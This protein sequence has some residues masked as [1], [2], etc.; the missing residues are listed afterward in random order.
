[1]SHSPSPS[2]NQP[3]SFLPEGTRAEQVRGLGREG[4]PATINRKQ[5]LAIMLSGRGSNMVALVDA[6][7][8]GALRELAE[9]AVVFSNNP[10]APGLATAAALGC[11]T[12]NLAPAGR[13]RADY[14]AAVVQLLREYELDYLVLAG[15]MRIL[16]P[17]LVRAYA[18]RILNIH[19]A[20]THL[21][22]GLHAYEWA[23]ENKL[24]ETKITVHLV[25][26]GLDTGPVLAQRPVDLR[27]ANTLSEVE[28]R[29]LLVEHELYAD[30]LVR[31]FRGQI[32]PSTPASYP[33]APPDNR[34]LTTEN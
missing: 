23:F 5:R 19:P 2:E 22:Q 26:E 17:V 6:I 24:P 8:M 28:R 27:G 20:D 3:P 34:Q 4:E 7:Q 25:N 9:V 30:T 32:S 14:D 13:K 29:G 15:Y 12:A 21:H 10:D 16:S 33:A 18:G 31:L 1:M 11:Q